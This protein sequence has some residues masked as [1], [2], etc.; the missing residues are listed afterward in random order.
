MKF[1]TYVS[2][3]ADLGRCAQSPLV[4]EVLLEPAAL[5]REGNLSMSDAESLAVAAKAMKLRPVLVWDILL[6]QRT[7]DA[8]HSTLSSCHWAMFAAVRVQDVGAAQWLQEHLPHMPIQLDVQT[9]NHNLDALQ[10]WCEVWSSSLERLILS[11]ELPEEKIIRYCQE[12]PVAC[13]ILGVGRILLFYS[14]RTLLASHVS[15]N[16]LPLSSHTHAVAVSEHTH[17][18]PL[19]VV[20]TQHG[21]FLYL[22]KDQ[23]ILD[24]M[25]ALWQAG[26][27][28]MRLDLRHVSNPGEATTLL[29]WVLETCQQ[30]PS[31]LRRSWPRPTRAP[32]FKTNNTT[33]Q[34]SRMKSQH[35]A[36]RDD[37]TVAEILSTEKPRYLVV[38]VLSHASSLSIVRMMLPSGEQVDLEQPL[39]FQ[40]LQGHPVEHLETQQILVA[41]WIKKSCPGALLRISPKDL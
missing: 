41:P 5:A 2:S 29:P 37:Q 14:P 3:Q 12:L 28:T 1:S 17:Y 6:P 7:L 33:G 22:D 31:A 8:L 18:K 13:E 9:G 32:F 30:N 21:T 24:R 16:T 4:T 34:F 38:R 10:T 40:T 36:F 11:I 20:E 27:D 19:P 26:L 35:H 23:C 25:D 15:P 39:Q